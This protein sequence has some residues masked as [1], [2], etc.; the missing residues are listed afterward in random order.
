MADRAMITYPTQRLL[1]VIDE[2]ARARDAATALAAAGF[3]PADVLVLAG[4]DGRAELTRLG[5]RPNPL[6]RLTRVFQFMS[7]D[8]LPDFLVY[9]RAIDDGRSVIAVRVTDKA[10]IAPVREVLERYEAHF[11]NYFG[12]LST[13]EISR[14]RGPEPEIPDA[15]RR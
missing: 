9:E 11:L 10:R 15:L 7:M 5:S 1:G 2:P 8:Q 6:S 4:P 14:W 3:V 13:Q 12:R